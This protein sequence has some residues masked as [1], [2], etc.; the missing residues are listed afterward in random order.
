MM[1]TDDRYLCPACSG[2]FFPSSYFGKVDE[3]YKR[4]WEWSMTTYY[5]ALRDERETYRQARKHGFLRI[6]G[7]EREE[8]DAVMG[9]V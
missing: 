9:L 2:E 4:L 1:F 3:E 8:W 7:R 6:M 5:K